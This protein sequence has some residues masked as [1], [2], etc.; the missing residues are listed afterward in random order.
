[1]GFVFEI[2]GCYFEVVYKIDKT[3]GN[4][5][6]EKR[7]KMQIHFRNKGEDLAS[8][9]EEIEKIYKSIMSLTLK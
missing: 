5:G 6:Q 4:S 9:S 8:C 3:F 7:E 2:Q 1:M